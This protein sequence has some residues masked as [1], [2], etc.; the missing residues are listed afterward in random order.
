MD[1]T[2]NSRRGVWILNLYKEPKGAFVTMT[3]QM[4]HMEQDFSFF[5]AALQRLFLC[6]L[7]SKKASG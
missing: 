5:V 1:K 4:F 3:R 6:L 2:T 7:I